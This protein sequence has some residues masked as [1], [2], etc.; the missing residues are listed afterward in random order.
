MRQWLSSGG[1]QK[2]A[3]FSA[4]VLGIALGLCGLNFLGIT[5]MGRAGGPVV[6]LAATAWIELAAIILS[7]LGLVVS[8]SLIVLA[9]AMGRGAHRAP[10]IQRLFDP[11]SNG[12]EQ[13]RDR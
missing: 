11:G 6:V 2:L 12:Q 4:I 13:D 10:D 3:T 8:L 1:P 5:A 9:S 7:I